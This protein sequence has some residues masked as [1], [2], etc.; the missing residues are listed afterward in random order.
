MAAGAVRAR[1]DAEDLT[2]ARSADAAFA[3]AERR[4]AELQYQMIDKDARWTSTTS[5]SFVD[6]WPE[7]WQSETDEE[8]H[9]CPQCTGRCAI[10]HRVRSAGGAGPVLRYEVCVRCGVVVS[11]LEV[12]PAEVSVRSPAQ[13]RRGDPVTA[14]VTIQAP[15][16]QPLDVAVGTSFF[17]EDRAHCRIL[18]SRSLTLGP[19]ERTTTTFVG[20]TDPDLTIPD[21]QALK[22]MIAADGAVRCLPRTV[23]IRV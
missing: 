12:F 18:D 15:P 21:A 6:G 9:Q 5:A 10:R 2:A 13:V 23:W 16:E 1:A 11:G 17:N 3:E 8:I 19:G 7:P 20:T 14:D 22:V 4:L